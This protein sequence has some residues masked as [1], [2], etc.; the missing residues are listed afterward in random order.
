M[1]GGQ[2][3]WCPI[4]ETIN[5]KLVFNEMVC[6][7]AGLG[8]LRSNIEITLEKG[9]VTRVEGESQAKLFERW[10][11]SFNDPT[12]Y[13]LAHYSLGLNPG[14]TKLTGRGLED[15]RVF[16]CMEFGMGSQ[17]YQIRGKTW[18]SASHADGVVLKP[19]IILDGQTIEKEGKYA[20][21]ELVKLC[22]ELGVK[23]Y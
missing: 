4:E 16:G 18:K 19:T 1:L 2:V 22:K 9:V 14:V 13:W 17:H 15:E 7:S 5:G 12:M 20:H 23:G 21:P 10:L 8:P 11:V 6:S 3:S